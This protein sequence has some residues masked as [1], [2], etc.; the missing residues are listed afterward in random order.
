MEK[1]TRYNI[2]RLPLRCGYRSIAES[3]SQ[4]EKLSLKTE[5]RKNPAPANQ[6]KKERENEMAEQEFEIENGKLIK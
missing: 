2:L 6:T 4:R 3:G 5:K 1:N